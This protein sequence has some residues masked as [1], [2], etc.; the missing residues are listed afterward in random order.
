[1]GTLLILLHFD[2]LRVQDSDILED[3]LESS[4]ALM[5]SM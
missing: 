5:V 4:Y 2:I 3:H 1:M